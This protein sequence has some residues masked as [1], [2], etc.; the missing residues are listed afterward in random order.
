MSEPPLFEHGTPVQLHEVRSIRVSLT[1]HGLVFAFAL[2]E[3]PLQQI[4]WR[5]RDAV[6]VRDVARQLVSLA[7]AMPGA[8]SLCLCPLFKPPCPIHQPL[9]G[10]PAQP[11]DGGQ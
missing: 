10:E 1:E 2:A 6:Q 11:Q 7:E 8:E 5:A 9:I 4:Q 3:G